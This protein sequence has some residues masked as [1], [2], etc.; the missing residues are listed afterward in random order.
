[1]SPCCR[2]DQ[3]CDTTEA[4]K[5]KVQAGTI[6][7]PLPPTARNQYREEIRYLN[8]Q[9]NP[10]Q[11]PGL[12]LLSEIILLYWNDLMSNVTILHVDMFITSHLCRVICDIKAIFIAPASGTHLLVASYT[13][14]RCEGAVFRSV[15][16]YIFDLQLQKEVTMYFT[17]I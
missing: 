1:M 5:F 7:Y 9:P 11:E 8:F 16:F 17:S 13:Q 3:N 14:H 15:K 4:A 12:K 2:R 6:H 10:S